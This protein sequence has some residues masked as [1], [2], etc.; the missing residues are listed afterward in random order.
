MISKSCK[1]AIR[2]CVFVASKVN[3]DVK[4]SMKEIAN[5]IEAPVAFT[6]KILQMLNKRRIITSLKGPYGG[7]YCEKYQLE[8]PI[9]EIV[10]AIDGLAVFKECVM[11][12]HQCSDQHPCPMHFEYSK[13]KEALMKSFS[14][15][16]IG[17]LA[18]KLIDG[19]SY[20]TNN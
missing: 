13:T 12:L 4:V 8:T 2:A 6:G 15:T 9:L 18:D 19:N 3:D 14:E 5:E 11:G 10:N 1:Y 7:F 16:T 17:S 20:L